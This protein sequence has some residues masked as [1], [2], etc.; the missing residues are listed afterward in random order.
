MVVF[1]SYR[2]F[3][4]GTVSE[5]V[6]IFFTLIVYYTLYKTRPDAKKY[7]FIMFF[8]FISIMTYGSYERFKI[9][10]KVEYAFKHKTYLV[11]EGIVDK[12]DPMPKGGHKVESFEVN[13]V[14]FEIL[15]TGN[16]PGEKTLLYTLTKNRNG[17]IQRNGQHVKIYYIPHDGTN[18]II[19]MWVYD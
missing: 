15:Y 6:G 1:E 11:V 13:N 18:E 16:Y 17:P 9:S 10:E 7:I 2:G 4:L 5:L 3:T 12:L 14:L 8:I 19:K